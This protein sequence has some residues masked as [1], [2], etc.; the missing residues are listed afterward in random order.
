MRFPGIDL[1]D[2]HV[3]VTVIDA[4]GVASACERLE[5]RQSSVSRTIA[6]L[7]HE[8]G[9]RLFDR[10]RRPMRPTPA[11]LFLR[12]RADALLSEAESLPRLMADRGF[13]ALATLSLGLVESLAA[14]FVPYL[15]Q[16]LARD[17]EEI[18]I[19]S[20]LAIAHRK[21]FLD[22][23]LDIV[24]TSDP[25]EEL[26]GLER[27]HIVTEPYRLI[28]PQSWGLKGKEVSLDGLA[29]H[30]PMIRSSDR[31]M[32]GR[33]VNTHLRRLRVDVPRRF[34]FDSP[35]S[36]NSMVALGYGWAIMTPFLIHMTP[37]NL[38]RIDILRFPGARLSRTLTLV[39]RGGEFGNLP[40][41]IAGASRTILKS[42]YLPEF[43]RISGLLS[44]DIQIE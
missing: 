21:S 10:S 40:E 25:M 1:A 42:H 23:K 8:L 12:K 2:L 33:Q 17:V 13:D 11:G 38:D 39:A 20:G 18:S 32:N 35:E 22:R 29:L 30:A 37:H 3:F 34:D 4:G 24:I 7:E 19:H 36:V 5:M 9:H 26:D 14:P 16:S 44:D 31:S 28:A 27:H 15:A 41:R 43:R 6:K